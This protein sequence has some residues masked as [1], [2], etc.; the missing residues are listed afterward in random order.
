MAEN[1]FEEIG[2]AMKPDTVETTITE[3]K[4]EEKQLAPIMPTLPVPQDLTK[5]E[6]LMYTILQTGSIEAFE[7]FVALKERTQ[8][9]QAKALFDEHFALMQKEYKPVERTKEVWNKEHTAILYKFAPL[10]NL[11]DIYAPIIAD[12]G[13]SY[14]WSEEQLP[15]QPDVKRLHCIVAGYGFEK[16]GY[17]D[18][19]ISAATSFTN[20]AQQRGVSTSY[21]KRLSF[22]NAF[23]VIIKD[24]DN[25][26]DFEADTVLSVA[27]EIA[28]IKDTKSLEELAKVFSEVYNAKKAEK[29]L[30]EETKKTQL[31]LINKAKDERKKA[32][33]VQKK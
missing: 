32:F 3:P 25:E 29:D 6:W 22:V 15:D 24:E 14:H 17:V 11:L 31:N 8:E 19:P 23:G 13:F 5:D 33:V 4:I 16:S 18:I 27:T 9:R 26:N 20:S 1:L 12:H 21:G 2:E 7:K 30:D 10:D 28:K